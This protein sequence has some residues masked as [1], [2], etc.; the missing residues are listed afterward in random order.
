MKLTVAVAFA[1]PALSL[2]NPLQIIRDD[3]SQ[4]STLEIEKYQAAAD[5]TVSDLTIFG[6]KIKCTLPCEKKAVI[7]LVELILTGAFQPVSKLWHH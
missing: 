3:S 4:N 7:W 5:Q 6:C 1:L 2:A